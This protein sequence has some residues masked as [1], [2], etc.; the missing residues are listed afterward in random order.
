MHLLVRLALVVWIS[1]SGFAWSQMDVYMQALSLSHQR[2][3][4]A[5]LDLLKQLVRDQPCLARAHRK[6]LSVGARA[7]RSVD[8]LSFLQS[9]PDQDGC[10][11]YGLALY[12]RQ[13]KQPAAAAEHARSVIRSKPDLLPAYLE[14]VDLVGRESGSD[15]EEFFRGLNQSGPGPSFGLGYLY[16]TRGDADKALQY[17][18]KAAELS[19]G[20]W[21]VEEQHYFL[22]YDTDRLT[23]A[24]DTLRRMLR[25][26][27]QEGDREREGIALGRLGL[28]EADIGNYYA[29]LPAL[30]RSID[31]VH[32]LG[33]YN[34]EQIFRA[35]L[36]LVYLYLGKYGDALDQCREALRIARELSLPRS[37]GRNLGLIAGIHAEMADYQQAIEAYTGSI[38]SARKVMDRPSEADQLASLSLVHG[39]L[40]DH[41]RG[42][43]LVKEALAIAA[44]L[45]NPWLEGRFQEILGTML[46][47]LDRRKEAIDAYNRG[48]RI[49]SKIGDRLGAA[50]RLAYASE[51]EAATGRSLDAQ[52][53]LE[54]AL[55]EA[56]AIGARIIEGR[57]WN[58]LGLVRFNSGNSQG[59]REAYQHG[60]ALGRETNMPEVVWRANAGLSRV[61]RTQGRFTQ[62]A[63]QNRAAIDAIERIRGRLGTEEDKAGFLEDKIEVYRRQIALL[64]SLGRGS[65]S[66]PYSSEA[67]QYAERARARAFLDSIAEPHLALQPAAEPA[68]ASRQR[69]IEARLSQ[70][71][72]RRIAEDSKGAGDPTRKRQLSSALSDAESEYVALRREIRSSNPSYAA[73]RYPEPIHLSTAQ[74]LAGDESVILA[75]SLGASSSYLFAVS[76]QGW[77]VVKLPSAAILSKRV[78]ELLQAVAAGPA[79]LSFTNYIVQAT[80][81]YRDLI[82]PVQ[83]LLSGK[84]NLI[85]VPD[86]AL[87]YLPFAALLEPEAVT[88]LGG[89][90]RLPYLIRRYALSYSPSVSVLKALRERRAPEPDTRKALLAVAEPVY[91][92][93]LPLANL[94]FS[95]KEVDSISRTY[96]DSEA[97]VLKGAAA[98]ERNVKRLLSDY[99]VIHFAVH[100]I[101]D[102]QRPYVSGLALTP[103]S[104]EQGYNG[105]LQV[106][107]IMGL[108]IRADL[109]VLSACE[110]AIGKR[111]DGE[112]LLGLT[113]AFLYAGSASVVASLWNV[114]D[115]S[116]AGLMTRFYEALRSTR[117]GVSE[118]LRQA[119][120]DTINSEFA[121]PYYWAP[122]SLVGESRRRFVN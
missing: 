15:L 4:E 122:F 120:L 71:Q 79:R 121:H 109:V 37:A 96:T 119:Q 56:Q 105:L 58:D 80:A 95:G 49:A 20:A 2:Q 34:N 65:P 61:S 64:V 116:S 42:L 59:A 106:Y 45:K 52:Q 81:L 85:I 117:M 76:Q 103:E 39:A 43:K 112:G 88:V 27:E 62:A 99:R 32:D 26:A 23:L 63:A 87:H 83:P 38:E 57:I 118:A 98:T 107:E 73:I 19:N 77:R 67:F 110:T 114:N 89:V 31:L 102:R 30:R 12:R 70:L 91:A 8:V 92:S 46:A 93:S 100:G 51:L 97:T 28:T 101:V 25:S 78:E 54:R 13:Q 41:E 3:N 60:L 18:N 9:L 84:R 90:S 48:F 104:S 108:P 22:Y 50:T 7:G 5:A 11:S 75:Y 24:L 74:Q 10:A 29:A 115:Q 35:N 16:R 17:L 86:G 47:G 113:R 111:M 44:D 69:E 66:N 1:A 68:L 14:L 21:E 33:D 82:E 72:A 40:G 55:K 53:G 36:G 94:P 6:L